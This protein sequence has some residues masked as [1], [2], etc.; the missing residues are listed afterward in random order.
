MPFL[1]PKWPLDL[2]ENF[3]RKA[4]NIIPMYILAPF[5]VQNIKKSLEWIKSDE[6]KPFLGPKWPVSPERFFQKI[7]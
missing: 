5:I 3:F 2:N 6:D 4:I 7:D 1:G